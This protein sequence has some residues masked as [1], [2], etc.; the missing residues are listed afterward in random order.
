MVKSPGLLDNRIAIRISATDRELVV[1]AAAS[2]GA[3]ASEFAR[4]ILR[5]SAQRTLADRTEFVLS[6]EETVLW[7]GTHGT[8]RAGP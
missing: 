7:E 3:S 4:D 1:R 2:T 8:A 5:V 6:P